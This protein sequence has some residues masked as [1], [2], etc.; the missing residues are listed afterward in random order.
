MQSHL[1]VLKLRPQDT[2]CVQKLQLFAQ[3]DPLFSLR[4]ARF[5]S[6]FR[7]GSARIRIDKCRFSDVRNTDNHRADRTVQDAAFAVALD[8]LFAGLLYGAVDR[9][10]AGSGT[11]INLHN[12]ISLSLEIFHPGIV[13]ALIGKVRFVQQDQPCFVLSKF[14]YIR[15][16]ARCRNSRIDQLN[17]QV[18]E[19]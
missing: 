11:G 4:D 9:F 14:I 13:S 15:V 1:L 3:T 10:H 5:V 17:H 8:F 18:D 19:L 2:R 12:R 7:T 16:A 6:G